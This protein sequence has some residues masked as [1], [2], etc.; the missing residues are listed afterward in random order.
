M[1]GQ[2]LARCCNCQGCVVR[3]PRGLRLDS[4]LGRELFYVGLRVEETDKVE[5]KKCGRSAIGTVVS[6][7]RLC[8]SKPKGVRL[9]SRLGREL[10][11]LR[12][13]ESGRNRL[14]RIKKGSPDSN[15]HGGVMVKAVLFEA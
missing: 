8:C 5:E 4:R 11:I 2:Q 14:S 12:W 7:S 6:W 3:S 10:L 15:W 9:D 13:F 1:A